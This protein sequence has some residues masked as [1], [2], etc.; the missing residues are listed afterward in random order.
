M[1]QLKPETHHPSSWPG[2]FDLSPQG[3]LLMNAKSVVRHWNEFGPTHDFEVEISRLE[4]AIKA[5]A[6]AEIGK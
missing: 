1:E 5:V 3:R 6:S 4:N 2:R